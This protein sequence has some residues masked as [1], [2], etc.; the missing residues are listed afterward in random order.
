MVTIVKLPLGLSYG[1]IQKGPIGKNGIDLKQVLET[2]GSWNPQVTF[3]R[4]EPLVPSTLYPLSSPVHKTIHVS[5]EETLMLDLT[6][7]EDDLLTF[8]H[9]KTRYNIRLAEKKGVEVRGLTREE[10]P[11]AWK[12]FEETAERDAF[13]L[14]GRSRYES[15]LEHFSGAR[16]VGAFY[17]GELLAVNLQVDAFGTRTY[18]H[19]ASSNKHRDVMAPYAIHWREIVHAKKAGLVRYDFWGVSDTNPA[20]RG[21]TRFKLGF[22]GE[23]FVSPGTF[24]FILDKPR[25]FFYLVFRRIGR[26]I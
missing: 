24:D 2:I 3:I 13:R 20:W 26:I 12:I 7:T 19:G 9:Q 25:Y 8:M 11:D 5:P 21:I 10:W 23:R 17:E 15:W 16:L 1:L 6:K 4:F 22:G 14:H 18:L